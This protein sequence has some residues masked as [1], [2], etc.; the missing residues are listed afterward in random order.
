[1]VFPSSCEYTLLER[2]AIRRTPLLSVMTMANQA[3]GRGVYGHVNSYSTSPLRPLN[4][5]QSRQSRR[6]RN[7]LLMMT[8]VMTNQFHNAASAHPRPKKRSGH[9]YRVND[10]LFFEKDCFVGVV[11]GGSRHLPS[12][13]TALVWS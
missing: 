10:V 7:L 11:G 1:M 6:R 2:W 4:T 9:R 8:M 12:D 5:S 3:L 13:A